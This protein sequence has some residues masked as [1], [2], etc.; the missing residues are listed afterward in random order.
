MKN[1]FLNDPKVPK[2]AGFY[3]KLILFLGF[4]V[5]QGL[6]IR[7]FWLHDEQK[8][9]VTTTLVSTMPPPVA[10]EPPIRALSVSDEATREQL[11]AYFGKLPESD[12]QAPPYRSLYPVK[13]IYLGQGKDLDAALQLAAWS[14]VNAFV[15]DAKESWGLC[16]PSEVPLA[17]EMHANQGTIDL[18]RIIKRCHDQGV[19][20]ICRIVCFKDSSMTQ[21]RPDLCLR[22]TGENLL[23]FPLEGGES[24]ANPYDHRVWDYLLDVAREVIS[25]GA[26]EIQFDYVRFPTGAP[27]N[28]LPAE[29][30]DIVEQIPKEFAI[31]RFLETARIELQ[32]KLSTP[33]SADLFS[34]VMTSE[35]DGK[36]IG[37]NWQSIGLTG[38]EVLCPMIYPSHYANA[39]AGSQGNGV[40]SYIGNGFFEMPDLEPYEVVTNALID[41][42]KASFQPG[43]CRLRPWLQAFTAS[44]L[45]PGYYQEYTPY[46]I[47]QQIQALYD[48]GYTEWLLW[49]PNYTYPDDI[50]MSAEA[51][52]PQEAEQAEASK[53]A[54]S[55]RAEIAQAESN[56]STRRFPIVT[57]PPTTK[58]ESD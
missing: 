34:V 41:G 19:K 42:E 27:D 23:T 55:E 28:D 31:N 12:P 49:E 53:A 54:A 24:F 16:Y 47:T 50:F 9:M 39:S 17:K 18:A 35:V 10:T 15:I 46:E 51:A 52:A 26:D 36:L 4:I 43:Y 48:K 22:D 14:E 40:G 56:A 3:L 58:S 11:D 45:A 44:W 32:E 30:L 57:A 37:Q 33:V 6:I 7:Y 13:G 20:V 25:F 1:I 38:I 8:E 21:A 29:F 5:L 2:Q